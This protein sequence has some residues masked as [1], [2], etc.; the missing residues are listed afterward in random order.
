MTSQHQYNSRNKESRNVAEYP[1]LATL[2]GGPLHGYEMVRRL[3]E[4]IGSVWRLRKS[5]LYA[6]LANLEREGFV[7]HQRIGH[8]KLPA[9]NIFNLTPDGIKLAKE[10][11]ERPVSHF[12]DIRLQF[13]TK[14]WFV[15]QFFPERERL[16]IK[17]QLGLCREKVTMFEGLRESCGNVVEALSYDLKIT[18]IKSTVSWLEGLLDSIEMGNQE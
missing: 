12:R 1:V 17:K 10:W 8:D 5:Q 11:L 9:K 6:L 7:I 16:L 13:V 2:L 4:G 18:V 3:N 14:L 15:R